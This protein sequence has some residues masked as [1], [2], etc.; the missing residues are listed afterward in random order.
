MRGGYGTDG[1]GDAEAYFGVGIGVGGVSVVEGCIKG[2]GF[3]GFVGENGGGL[4][5]GSN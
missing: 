3:R 5:E 4:R 2:M 1:E